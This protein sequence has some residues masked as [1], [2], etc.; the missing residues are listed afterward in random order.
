MLSA[1]NS[2]RGSG[3][4]NAVRKDGGYYHRYVHEK[5]TE[6]RTFLSQNEIGKRFFKENVKSVNA[7]GSIK[8]NAR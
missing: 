1:L 4:E 6:G 2:A 7:R 3:H 8:D 5:L